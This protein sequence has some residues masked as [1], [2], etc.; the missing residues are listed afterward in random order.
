MRA[1]VSPHNQNPREPNQTEHFR[2]KQ[3]ATNVTCLN[4]HRIK[5]NSNSGFAAGEDFCKLF[6]EDME[7]LYLLS[8]F[9]TGNHD[10]AKQCFLAGLDECISGISVLHE[11]A[12]FWAR[13][14]IVRHA[15]R[16]TAQHA[17]SLRPPGVELAGE[18][19]VSETSLQHIALARV[20]ALEDLERSVFVLSILEDYSTQTCAFLLA[21]SQKE[22]LEARARALQH[23]ADFD[24]VRAM[25]A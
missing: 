7:G 3:E 14:V 4:E 20:L 10:N 9:L 23:I 22:V 2:R 16:I 24:L 13:H 11:W 1:T 5:V 15:L 17:G 8:L 18:G 19:V 25:L 6:M 12:D 21:V